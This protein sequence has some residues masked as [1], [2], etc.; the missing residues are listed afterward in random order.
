MQEHIAERDSSRKTELDEQILQLEEKMAQ[1][2]GRLKEAVERG[3]QKASPEIDT[4]ERLVDDLRERLN[5]KWT[6]GSN[7]ARKNS[8]F[9]R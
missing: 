6:N 7:S 2:Q 5:E 4:Y 8:F 1:M 9:R 3:R